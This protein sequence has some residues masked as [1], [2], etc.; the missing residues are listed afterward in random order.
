VET[1]LKGKRFQDS[2]N[3]ERNVTAERIS[4]PLEVLAD[5]FQKLL[6]ADC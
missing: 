4:V 3:I 6:L 5:R 2:Q 1:A